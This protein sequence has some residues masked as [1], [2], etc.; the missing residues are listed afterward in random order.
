MVHL[1][2]RKQ[3]V[4]VCT[5]FGVGMGGD[6]DWKYVAMWYYDSAVRDSISQAAFLEIGNA[7][8]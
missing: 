4:Y 7:G 1:Q 3:D 2:S 6:E 5:S 8:R